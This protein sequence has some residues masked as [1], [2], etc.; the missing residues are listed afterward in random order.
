MNNRFSKKTIASLVAGTFLLV[1]VALPFA[2]QAATSEKQDRPAMCQRKVD[3]EKAAARISQHFGISKE[4]VLKYQNQGYTFRD[5]TKA[6]FL[7]KASGK[8]FESVVVLKTTDKTWKTIAQ[9]LGVTKEQ[10]KSTHRE[11]AADRINAKTGMDKAEITGLMEQG[12]KGRDI[13]MAGLLSKKTN[14]SASDIIQLKK[15]NNRW[16]DVAETIGVDRDAFKAELKEM[17]KGGHHS[18]MRHQ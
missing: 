7:A 13:T 3:P 4:S 17:H 12:Y 16:L 5:L 10:M 15:I 2:V 11:L 9:E 8:P 6:A 18:R 1:G 14:R